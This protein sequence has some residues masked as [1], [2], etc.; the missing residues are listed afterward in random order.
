MSD[1]FSMNGIEDILDYFDIDKTYKLIKEQLRDDEVSPSGAASDHLKPLWVKYKSIHPDLNV[2]IDSSVMYAVD[3]RFDAICR[4]F[5]DI[6]SKKFGISLDM[7]WF[8]DQSRST[9]QSIALIMYSFFVLDLES[10]IKEVLYKYIVEHKE[11][12]ALHF[13][14]NIKTRKD[15]P[16]LSMKK[17]MEP[18]YAI[19]GACINDVCM[20]I[21]DQMDEEEF[22]EYLDEDYI[23]QPVVKDLFEQ[24]HMDGKFVGNIYN[25]FINNNAVRCRIVFDILSLLKNNHKKEKDD[26]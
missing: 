4:M 20:W 1:E 13:G 16:Y 8:G 5:I 26:E 3:E 10:N 7:G 18:E 22:F 15:S 24:G 12:L 25:Y 17:S 2:G 14:D 11:D 6:I 9:L 21:L 23:P 19:I